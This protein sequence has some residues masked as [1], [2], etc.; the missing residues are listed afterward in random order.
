MEFKEWV[1]LYLIV[2]AVVAFLIK[3]FQGD[4]Y[5]EIQEVV[6]PIEGWL[7]FG[8]MTLAWPCILGLAL[9]EYLQT[10]DNR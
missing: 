8:S 4:F 7:V 5:E 10:K 3:L 1:A 9:C 2:G 6:W